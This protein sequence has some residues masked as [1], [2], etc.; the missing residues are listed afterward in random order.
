VAVHAVRGATR[1]E[2]DDRE[3]LLGATRE[4]LAQVLQ[5]NRLEPDD[6]LSILFTATADL[7]SVAPAM[8]AR[9][10]GL[11]D[12]AL[13]C[14]QEM[15]VDGSM[16]RV[17]RLMAHVRTPLPRAQVRHVYL[18]GTETLRADVPPVPVA[19]GPA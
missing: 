3:V 13:L 5:V 16:P 19:G 11:H 9:Q 15:A 4:L 17:V 2:L 10:L 8:A 6:V 18:K 1:V 7:R 14:A 12:A